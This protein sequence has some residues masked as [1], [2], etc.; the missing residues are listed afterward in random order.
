MYHR[1]KR[2]AQSYSRPAKR[3]KQMTARSSGGL[4]P[5]YRGFTPRAFSLGE[6][7]YLDVGFASDL[8]TGG[9]MTLLNGLSP[10]SGASGR[11]GMKVSITSIQASGRLITTLATGVEQFIRH[12]IVIDRQPNG[13]AP[14]ALTDILNTASVTSPRNLANRK[15]F[16]ILWDKTLSMGSFTTS[17]GTP[18]SRTWKLYMKFRRPITTEYNTGVA[19]TVAD[20]ASNS[21]YYMTLG[22]EAAGNTDVGGVANFRIR[23]VDN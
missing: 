3:V 15:R 17:T 4:I 7:K 22:T 11:I 20:I 16:K 23:Y 18:T 6:W 19:G 9:N 13:A 5:T 12:F 2:A 1:K 21:L 8:N 10:S 14:V